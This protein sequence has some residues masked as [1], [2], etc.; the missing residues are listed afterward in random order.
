MHALVVECLAMLGEKSQAAELYPIVRE[1]MGTGT[2]ALWPIF[3][4]TQTIAGIA[5]SAARQWDAA[6]EHFQLAMQQAKFFP[7]VLERAEIRRFHAMM[8]LDR[9]ALGDREKTQTLLNEAPQSYKHIGM[10]RHVEMAQTL[11]ARCR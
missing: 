6:E 7:N 8:L 9:G 5:A 3:R 11:L 4:F 1:L 10:P 2:T